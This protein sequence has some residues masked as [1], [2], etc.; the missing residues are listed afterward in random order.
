MVEEAEA[1]GFDLP[2]VRRTL[3]VREQMVKAGWGDR[4]ASWMPAFWPAHVAGK[5]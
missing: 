1:K 5:A 3:E 4:D 2:P